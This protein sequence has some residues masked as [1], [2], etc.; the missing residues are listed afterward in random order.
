MTALGGIETHLIN[1]ACHL[2]S[3]G[4]RVDF[5]AKFSAVTS[6]TLQKLRSAGVRYH[7]F[8]LPAFFRHTLLSSALLY[9]NS[10]G[11]ASPLIWRL[12]RRGRR[13]FHHCHTACSESETGYW[14]RS[15]LKF[16]RS[17]PH[18]SLVACSESTARNLRILNPQREI[19]V[20]PYFAISQDSRDGAG[21]QATTARDGKLHFGFVG[22]LE[23]SKGIDLLVRASASTELNDICWHVFGDGSQANLVRQAGGPHFV[24]HGPFDGGTPLS[25]IYG[26][27]DAVV[28]PSLHVE[29]SPLCL[30]EAMAHGKPWIAFDQGGVKELVADAKCCLVPQTMD[31][32]GFVLAV[33]ALR[34]SIQERAIDPE[35]L[36]RHYEMHFSP[37]EVGA[38]WENFCLASL[39]GRGRQSDASA[40]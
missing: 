32:E 3:I 1:V 31:F 37:R 14:T 35:L 9:T 30:I 23:K 4:W 12:S 27:L 5:C 20:L 28:L 33:K 16:I 2:S 17:K 38:R 10:Q 11:S 19:H 24:Y 29:G 40:R 25:E 8:P 15:Y 13:G 18:P 34:R 39:Q 22:R 6:F 36:M 26:Q 7:R 21:Q